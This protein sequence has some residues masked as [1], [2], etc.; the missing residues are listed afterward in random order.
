MSKINHTV[1]LLIEQNNLWILK[2]E[3]IIYIGQTQYFVKQI[4]PSSFNV[5]HTIK[6]REVLI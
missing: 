3:E 6:W 5:K 2:A 4:V 1:T